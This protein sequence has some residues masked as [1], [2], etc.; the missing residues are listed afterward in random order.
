MFVRHALRRRLVRGAVAVGAVGSAVFGLA[1]TANAVTPVNYW[2]S[3]C[4]PQNLH[5]GDGDGCFVQH[6]RRGW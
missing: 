1:G 3:A 6:V 4:P 5:E 2:S